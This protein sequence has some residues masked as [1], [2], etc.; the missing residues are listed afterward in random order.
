MAVDGHTSIDAV[1]TPAWMLDGCGWTHQHAAPGAA[2]LRAAHS[3]PVFLTQSNGGTEYV[4]KYSITP[5]R[6]RPV[7]FAEGGSFLPRGLV[8]PFFTTSFTTTLCLH[9]TYS[10]PGACIAPAA[11]ATR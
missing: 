7:I 6:H 1:D 2:C 9:A 3:C 5:F 10:V 8:I 4:H 11:A